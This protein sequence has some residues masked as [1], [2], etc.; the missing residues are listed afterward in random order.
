M[1]CLQEIHLQ[2]EDIEKSKENMGKDVLCISIQIKAGVALIPGK[3]DK[4]AKKHFK[5]RSVHY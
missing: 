4:V 2:Y 1:F 5:E 3:K